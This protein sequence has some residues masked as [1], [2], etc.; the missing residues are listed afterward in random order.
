MSDVMDIFRTY[1]QEAIQRHRAFTEREASALETARK[2][3]EKAAL[4]YV[5]IQHAEI[6]QAMRLP[7][8]AEIRS[9][10]VDPIEN[11]DA[12]VV[13]DDLV[14][15]DN[16]PSILDHMK[17]YRSTQSSYSSAYTKDNVIASIGSEPPSRSFH[18]SDHTKDGTDVQHEASSLS[19]HGSDHTKDGT[20]VQHEASSLSL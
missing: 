20:D 15:S 16:L 14:D 19:L 9:Q 12:T 8:V 3:A 13:D 18:N 5:A 2:A 7:A 10:S 1:C 11:F 4:D 6:M 17:L